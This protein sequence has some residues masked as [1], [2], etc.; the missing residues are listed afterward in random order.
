MVLTLDDLYQC[1]HF[2][3]Y[4]SGSESESSVK[5]DLLMFL[6]AVYMPHY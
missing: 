6:L 5:L 1:Q 2:I 3:S 4:Y